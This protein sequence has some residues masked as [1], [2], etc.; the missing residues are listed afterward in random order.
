MPLTAGARLGPYEILA[1]IGA[2][3][4]GEVYRAR[5]TKLNRD[6]ALKVLPESLAANPDRIA[7]LEREAKALAA[8]NHPHIA[9]LHAF[10]EAA[11]RHFL[12][13]E[14]VDG[15]T[16]ADRLQR[17]ALT[18][19]DALRVGLQIAAALEAAHE[20]GVVHRDLKPA[21]VKL[22]PDERV[23]VLDFGLAKTME[24]EASAER[25]GATHSPTLSMLATEAGLI[26]GTAAYMSPEQAK[27]LTADHRSDVFAFGIVLYEM[28]TGRQPFLG[29]TAP[30]VMASILAREPNLN[31]LPIGLNP[32]LSELL[33]RCLEKNPKKRW[34]A[35]GD[36][37]MELE[38]IARAPYAEQSNSISVP[39]R[40][41]LWRRATPIVAAAVLSAVAATVVARNGRPLTRA[42]VTRFAIVLPEDASFYR[43]AAHILAISP[44]G[45]KLAYVANR[46]MFLRRLSELEARPVAGVTGD[47]SAPFFSPDGEWLGFVSYQDSLLKKIRI[48]GGAA[49]TLCKVNLP[50]GASWAGNSI[51]FEDPTKG[52]MRV[53]ADGGEPELLV[54]VRP[55]EGEASSPQLL[56]DGKTILFTLAPRGT[57]AERWDKSQVVLQSLTEASRRVLFSGGSDAQY[58]R[59]GHIVDAVAPNILAVAVDLQ[60]MQIRGGPV[61]VVEGVMRA[62]SVSGTAQLSVS[63]AGTLVY[64]P[65]G[66]Y[67]LVAARRLALVDRNGNVIP[68]PIPPAPYDS[69]RLSPDGKQ[70]TFGTDDGREQTIWVYDMMSAGTAPR[71]LTFAAR[72]VNP[73]WSLDGRYLIYRSEADG[74]VG[75]FRQLADGTG[76]PVRLTAAE[77]GEQHVPVSMEPSGKMVVYDAVG[78]EAGPGVGA[79]WMVALD[80]GAKPRLF[81]P[82]AESVSISPVFSP[83]GR[84][85]AYTAR[86]GNVP[87]Q[88]FVL[89]YPDL[90]AK[91]QISTEGGAQPFWSPDG[92]QLL[93]SATGV[94]ALGGSGGPRVFAVD[95]RS[96]PTFSSKAAAPAPIPIAIPP[97]F[98]ARIANAR[99]YDMTKDGKQFIV[100]APASQGDKHAALQINV[101]VNWFEELKARVPA[102]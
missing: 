38:T 92:R 52:I 55:E 33:N 54:P 2:G 102:K 59:S 98:T 71:R 17:G 62:V 7:R 56:E 61:P 1:A 14:L 28:L 13:M 80:G 74:K 34:Q 8:L 67:G 9:T 29:E 42:A 41:A 86:S 3:G 79:T 37:R 85:V 21:N 64:I 95:I 50:F 82:F 91:Y 63:D 49:V 81:A 35:A 65:T 22:T 97:E 26:L 19:E 70:L 25:I 15:E 68:L 4:M 53:S 75:L 45:T 5:D 40:P 99:T 12:V 6:V 94:F 88:V 93:Y 101:A 72:A 69:P 76:P 57:A 16:L 100:V 89:S 84:W 48:A 27:G 36:L 32:R 90:K 23:K 77:H 39:L 73:L 18:V 60:K 43:T 83:N 47:V 10:E 31:A 51:V 24:R 87:R 30:D 66:E 44:D 78:G 58:V 96:E 11:E 20:K 46:Q